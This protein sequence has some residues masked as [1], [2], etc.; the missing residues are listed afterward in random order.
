[1]ESLT[2]TSSRLCDVCDR[3]DFL[4]VLSSGRSYKNPIRETRQ[5]LGTVKHIADNPDCPICTFAYAFIQAE[6]DNRDISERSELMVECMRIPGSEHLRSTGVEPAYRLRLTLRCKRKHVVLASLDPVGQWQDINSL[7]HDYRMV[8]RP[9]LGSFDPALL[10]CWLEQSA[11]KRRQREDGDSDLQDLM[12]RGHFRLIEVCSGNVITVRGAT[13]YLTLSYVWGQCL[14]KKTSAYDGIPIGQANIAWTVDI[15]SLPRTIRDAAIL[16]RSI[17]EDY[18]WVDSICIDQSDVTDKAAV[19]EAM[20]GIYAGSVLTVVAAGG[21]DANAGLIGLEQRDIPEELKLS[22][23]QHGESLLFLE[24]QPTLKTLID[25][26]KWNTRGWTYQE[27]L[28]SDRCV[29]FTETEV[30][31]TCRGLICREA[32]ELIARNPP[33]PGTARRTGKSISIYDTLSRALGMRD[34]VITH[35]GSTVEAFTARDLS[36]E[37][38]RLFAFAGVLRL[39]QGYCPGTDMGPLSGLIAVSTAE[40][41]AYRFLEWLLWEPADYGRRA[42][43]IEHD[44]TGLRALPSWSWTGWSGV[45]QFPSNDTGLEPIV[46]NDT[47]I[48]C[49]YRIPGIEQWPYIPEPCQI[50]IQTGIVLH[51]WI[52]IIRCMLS[53]WYANTDPPGVYR[54]RPGGY[55]I[56]SC[57]RAQPEIPASLVNLGLIWINCDLLTPDVNE[58][59]DFLVLP[60]WRRSP[61]TK[62]DHFYLMLVRQ[63]GPYV[64]RVALSY[65]NDSIKRLS[66]LSYRQ[67]K[68][69]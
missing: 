7:Q 51:L 25:G 3:V 46:L 16:T 17:G 55:G 32:Y 19:I 2:P 39:L 9:V 47:N 1:M 40:S 11:D 38:D 69:I 44:T 10:R 67:V 6:G 20:G 58:L 23:M 8:R 68:L 28:L 12:L 56:V 61:E 31:L 48:Y 37:G 53:P 43:R 36:H 27:Y 35:Y 34:S 60:A 62:R 65:H 24:P 29:F 13:R 49:I 21:S 42:H 64:E 14:Q 66:T 50:S 41:E 15:E 45:V 22:F 54:I 5:I 33:F 63:R 18:L 26:S 59:Y 4:K 30:F 52:P 57:P